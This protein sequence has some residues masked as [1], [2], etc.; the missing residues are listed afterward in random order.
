MMAEPIKT[1]E[2]HYL[3]TDYFFVIKGFVNKVHLQLFTK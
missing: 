3:L 1:L 2:L